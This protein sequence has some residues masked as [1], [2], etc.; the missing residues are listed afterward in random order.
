MTEPTDSTKSVRLAYAGLII[1]VV[2]IVLAVYYYQQSAREREPSFVTDPVKTE[3]LKST[4]VVGVPIRVTRIDGTEI[5]S[6]LSA[7]RFYLW[8]NGK[9]PIRDTHILRQISIRLDDPNARILYPTLLKIS[10]EVTD[11]SVVVDPKNPEKVLLVNFKIL[12][13]DDG[14]TGQIIYEGKPDANL[15]VSGV[16]EGA[17][18]IHT[19]AFFQSRIKRAGYETL[20]L[21]LGL[22][23]LGLLA[24][25]RELFR[26]VKQTEAHI[27]KK[28]VKVIFVIAH[29]MAFSLIAYISYYRILQSTQSL[30]DKIVSNRV[31]QTILP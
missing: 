3:I 26:W 11:A 9:E 18:E 16:I 10:R 13:K 8:N 22:A 19:N 20:F 29:L 5:K 24:L 6:D 14:M 12:E 31:P 23:F 21:V 27:R 15:I 2:G 7:V 30:N 17:A 28:R 1:G 25:L 4:E